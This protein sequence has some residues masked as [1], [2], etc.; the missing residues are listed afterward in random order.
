MSY[1]RQFALRYLGSRKRSFVSLGTSFATVGV[2]LGV[3]AL[4]LAVSVS[5]GFQSQFRD[6]ILGVN[7]HVLVL[8]YSIDFREYRDVMKRVEAI[9]GVV[10]AAPFVINPTMVSHGGHTATGVLLKGIDPTRSGRVLDL[11]RTIVDGSLE[12]L[13]HEGARPPKATPRLELGNGSGNGGSDGSPSARRGGLLEAME[14]AVSGRG[15]KAGSPLAPPD[16]AAVD[17]ARPVDATPRGGFASTLPDDDVLPPELDADPCAGDGVLK[18]PSIAIG[19]AL[20]RQLDAR[21]GSCL[22]VTSP[23]IGLSIGGVAKPPVAKRFRV[24]ALFEAGFDQ[25]DSK[26]AYADLYEAQA[27]YEYG[28]SV[29]GIETRVDDIDRSKEVVKAIELDLQDGVYHVLDWM[30]L[31]RGLFTALVVQRIGVTVVLGLILVVAAFTVVAT[32]VMIVLE[33]QKEIALLKAIGAPERDIVRIFLWQGLAI[34]TV[35]T[36]LGLV[37]GALG[38][39]ALLHLPIDLDAKVYFISQLPV[40]VRAGEWAAI[41]AFSLL[42]ST[43][44]ALV[45]ARHA[46]RAVPAEGLR[47]RG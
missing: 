34:G 4:C 16:L 22:L 39:A 35:G 23:T 30:D 7:A 20:A 29:T 15:A 37:L 45:P 40:R 25:Y 6:K 3:A 36:A 33:K 41:A 5:G 24:I 27:F 2:A 19:R 28:D 21:V 14:A 26:L 44:A 43:L 18:L 17:P 9:P 46:A 10:A 32:L 38:C 47:P 1:V 13:R 11:P 42:L 31:N 12:D 8:K